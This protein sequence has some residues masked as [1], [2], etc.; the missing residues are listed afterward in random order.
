MRCP[1]FAG[2]GGLV[3]AAGVLAV[4]PLLLLH[5]R[6][7]AGVHEAVRANSSTR[8]IRAAHDHRRRRS[9][10]RRPGF[11]RHFDFLLLS[12]AL[13]GELHLVADLLRREFVGEFLKLLDLAC[14]P[15]P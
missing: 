13:D 12:A 5:V 11:Q 2:V 6:A 9:L 3:D 8:S 15:S 7:L 14:R 1:G 10:L 4:R